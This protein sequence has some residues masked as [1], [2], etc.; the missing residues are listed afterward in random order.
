MM[1]WA[2]FPQPQ[3]DCF[4]INTV[5]KES[6]RRSVPCWRGG[7]ILITHFTDQRGRRRG[8]AV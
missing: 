1:E 4:R 7:F 6:K 3:V 5:E 8:E 2:L